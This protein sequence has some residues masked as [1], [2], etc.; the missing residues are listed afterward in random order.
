VGQSS[1]CFTD[2][3]SAMGLTAPTG[4][5]GLTGTAL[6]SQAMRFIKDKYIHAA[7]VDALPFSDIAPLAKTLLE[8]AII[9]AR[10]QLSGMIQL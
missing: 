4:L 8:R 2:V 1:R 9:A 5:A 7:F 3:S 6:E 10:E